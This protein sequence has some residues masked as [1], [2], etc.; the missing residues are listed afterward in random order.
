LANK[1]VDIRYRTEVAS[2]EGTERIEA[3]YLRDESGKVTREATRGLY[4]FVGSKPRTDF[5]PAPIAKDE[6][7]FVLTGSG[8]ASYPSWK[9]DRAPCALEA[10]LSGVFASGDCRGGATKRVA[11]AIGDG[12][13]AVTCVHQVLRM[14]A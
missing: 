1:R 6:F 7:G 13:L 11:F 2:A 9:E 10:S 12:A 4:V 5:L 14:Q 8:V 3:V